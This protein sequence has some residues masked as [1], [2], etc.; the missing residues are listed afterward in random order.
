MCGCAWH[1]AAHAPAP[2]MYSLVDLDASL[3]E[4]LRSGLREAALLCEATGAGLSS[5]HKMP[6]FLNSNLET[7][8]DRWGR[9]RWCRSAV[10][11]TDPSPPK[12]LPP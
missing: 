3:C 8:N 12:S 4:I 11:G 5:C 6:I 1:P 9:Q 2:W 10:T 7:T